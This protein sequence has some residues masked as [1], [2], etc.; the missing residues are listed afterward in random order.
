MRFASRIDVYL[1]G[2]ILARAPGFWAGLRARW[3]GRDLTS[4]RVRVTME[5]VAFVTELRPAFRAMQINN[6]RSLVIDG[7]SVFHDAHDAKDDLP[8]LLDA[9]DE[10]V[11]V[12]GP[13]CKDLRLGV[14]HEEAGLQLVLEAKVVAEHRRG[15]PAAQIRVLGHL[16][17]LVPLPGES[18]QG[19]RA[20][21]EPLVSD[22]RKLSVL[23][24]QFEA[25]IARLHMALERSLSDARF[26]VATEVLDVAVS[27]T[28][29]IRELPGAPVESTAERVESTAAPPRNFSLSLE[30]RIGALMSGPPQYAVRLRRIEEIEE[31]IVAAL[32]DAAARGKDDIP[33]AIARA[34]ED[35]NRLIGE[36]NRNY[37]IE[38]NLAMDLSGQLLEMGQPWTP[39]A[40]VTIDTL[41]ARA[42]RRGR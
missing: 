22:G 32:G 25:Y 35:L 40:A 31:K 41:R 20:R 33:I 9:L 5:G 6:A 34:L 36:H 18:A 13:G 11:A 19:Y 8:A 39:R 12:F 24:A 2:E 7:V 4:D 17:D 30:E 42:L 38:R 29:E 1:P 23:R 15:E 10:H 27:P 3:G 28:V 26:T 16:T 21:I 14:E 37:P